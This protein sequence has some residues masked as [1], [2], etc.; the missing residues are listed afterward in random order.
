MEREKIDEFV[1]SLREMADWFDKH[2]EDLPEFIFDPEV[3]IESYVSLKDEMVVAAKALKHGTTL[4]NPV[5]K[6]QSTFS[7]ELHRSFGTKAKFVVWTSRENVCTRVQ[8]GTKSEPVK[9]VVE[10]GE[11]QEVPIYEWECNDSLLK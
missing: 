8:T 5:T 3:K 4:N 7:Y 2:G 1:S 11:M 6:D 10:T 9:K